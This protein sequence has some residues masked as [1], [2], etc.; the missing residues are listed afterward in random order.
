MLDLKDLCDF[1]E[2][3]ENQYVQGFEWAEMII[4]PG[5]TAP[6]HLMIVEDYAT[7]FAP[8]RVRIEK[9]KSLRQWP[10]LK[11]GKTPMPKRF[12]KHKYSA[13]KVFSVIPR[14]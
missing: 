5:W 4:E 12:S 14:H 3:I 6:I 1:C 7:A 10:L 9:D 8:K 2:R 13:S 11:F